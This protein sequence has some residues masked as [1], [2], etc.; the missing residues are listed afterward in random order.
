MSMID[1]TVALLQQNNPPWRSVQKLLSL[2]ELSSTTVIHCPAL[3]VIEMAS[4]PKPDVRGTGAYLQS[5]TETIG[6]VI[7]T[8]SINGQHQDFTE[9]RKAVKQRL[10]GH[11]PANDYEPFWLG[12]GRLLGMNSGRASWL[13]NFVT[14]YTEDQLNYGPQE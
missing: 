5:V 14:E 1:G 11:T 2:A 7:V 3:F 9:L 10:F 8:Q 4:N 6:V 13:D 12:N